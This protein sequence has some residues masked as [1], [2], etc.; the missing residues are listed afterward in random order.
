MFK[1][2][3]RAWNWRNWIGWLSVLQSGL[4]FWPG[5]CRRSNPWAGNYFSSHQNTC[6]RSQGLG[7]TTKPFKAVHPQPG[8]IIPSK[9]F[10]NLVVSG[11]KQWWKQSRGSF[12]CQIRLSKSSISFSWTFS[13]TKYW[14]LKILLWLILLESNA[15]CKWRPVHTASRN[16]TTLWD[17]HTKTTQ[18]LDQSKPNKQHVQAKAVWWG[19][20]RSH[21]S[22]RQ[23]HSF[24]VISG[25]L[26]IFWNC[27]AGAHSI[28]S[29]PLNIP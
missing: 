23:H 7:H 18:Y 3:K 15:P 26:P 4:S 12:L 10:R 2:K 19:L 24:H 16:A 1:P 14:I 22:C 21:D 28:H 20:H 13:Q 6:P 5:L 29:I 11:H 9:K 25:L 27:Q 17:W 8:K